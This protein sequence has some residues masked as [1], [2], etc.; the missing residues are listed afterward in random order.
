M[1]NPYSVIIIM[2]GYFGL[3]FLVALWVERKSSQGQNL[4]N[5]PVIYSLSLA[6][7]CTTWTYYGSVGNAA[8]SGMLFLTI[9]LGPTLAVILWWTVIRKIISDKKYLPLHQH[10]R[11]HITPLS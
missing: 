3:L 2:C 9:Y 7:Y 10:R 6:V 8:T 4:G 1:F 11:L 5:N